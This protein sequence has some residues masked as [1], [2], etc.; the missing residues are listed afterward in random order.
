[1]III[2][3]RKTLMLFITRKNATNKKKEEKGKK[4]FHIQKIDAEFKR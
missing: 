2:E 4:I 1:M 3:S